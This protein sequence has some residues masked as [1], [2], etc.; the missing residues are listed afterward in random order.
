MKSLAIR[1]EAI[2][3]SEPLLCAWLRYRAGKRRRPSIA[4]FALT[5]EFELHDLSD[6]ILA[7]DYRHGP[8]DLLEVCDPKPRLI[9]VAS[10]RDR[11][12]HRALYDAL[13]PGIDLSFLDDSFAC[14]PG[15]G[16]HRAVLRFGEFLRK[17]QHVMHLDIRRYFP[18]VDHRILF[19]LLARR[20]RDVRVARLI[21]RILESGAELYRRPE[22]VAFYGEPD[23]HR[24]Q[25]LPIGNLT[26]QWWGNLYLDGLDHFI[27]R[28]LEI[29]GYL[30][31]MDDL[32]C[33][34]D[35]PAPLRKARQEIAGWLSQNRRLRLNPRKGHI[36]PTHLPQMYLGY[37]ID[38]RGH[39]LGPKAVRRFRRN[40]ATLIARGERQ[41][42]RRVL[43]S[44]RGS[45][46]F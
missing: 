43:A 26:S 36:R 5:A 31:Y 21:A 10:P 46:E 20:L 44:W 18:T 17:Y 14:L 37:R 34:A 12:L 41:R 38:H 24:S 16:S 42:L 45:M 7:G 15:R 23:E 39:D 28:Q 9:A 4:R 33:F 3:G 13:A 8:Y 32:V 35:H 2:A 19:A 25:G 6:E 1:L 11:V 29:P 40:C 27:K 30:R 22:V